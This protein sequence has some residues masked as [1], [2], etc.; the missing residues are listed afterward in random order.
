MNS[1]EDYSRQWA[2]CD[3]EDLDTLYQ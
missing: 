1:V 2:K 3:K